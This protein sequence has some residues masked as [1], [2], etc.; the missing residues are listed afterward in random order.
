MIAPNMATTLT[1]MATTALFSRS[2]P[3]VAQPCDG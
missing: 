1:F 2:V 3:E